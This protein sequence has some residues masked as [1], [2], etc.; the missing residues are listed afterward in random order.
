[1]NYVLCQPLLMLLGPS[2]HLNHFYPLIYVIKIS[3]TTQLANKMISEFY[4]GN[5]LYS[6]LCDGCVL[7]LKIKLLNLVGHT[8]QVLLITP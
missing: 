6:K 1:M 4:F 8:G 5:H 3:T 7:P 2:S